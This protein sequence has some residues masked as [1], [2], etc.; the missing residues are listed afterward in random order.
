MPRT[1]NLKGEFVQKERQAN[2]AITPGDLIELMSTGKVRRHAGLG[3]AAQRAFAL[4]NDVIGRGITDDYAQNEV[5]KYGVFA[6]GAEVY[7]WMDINESC[8]I[9]DFLESNG[10]GKLQVASTPVEGTHVGI[11]L[12]QI[13]GGGGVAKRVKIEIV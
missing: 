10:T 2:A 6:P 13:T 4:E 12:E 7:A 9:G 8:N 1:V 5:V 11:A 3:T